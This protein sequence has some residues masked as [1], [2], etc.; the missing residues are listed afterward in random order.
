M[1]DVLFYITSAA[2]VHENIQFPSQTLSLKLFNDRKKNNICSKQERDPVFIFAKGRN[3]KN[4]SR[5]QKVKAPWIRK[6]SALKTE[7][8]GNQLELVYI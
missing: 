2:D 5:V 1:T 8:S 7:V 6:I 4:C 3:E